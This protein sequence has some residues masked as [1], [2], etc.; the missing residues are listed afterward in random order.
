MPKNTYPYSFLNLILYF[1]KLGTVGF[2]GS[3]ALA[4]YMRHDLV[5]KKRWIT[6]EDYLHGLALSQ[7]APGPLSAQLAI[8]IGFIKHKIIGATLCGLAFVLPSFVIVVLLSMVYVTFGNL[9]WIQKALYGVN[10]A[11]IGIILF[12]CYRLTRTT[13]HTLLQWVIMICMFGIVI[14]TKQENI[15]L[16]IL[17]GLITLILSSPP[18]FLSSNKLFGI[19]IPLL[20]GGLLTLASMNKL[21][22]LFF[23]FLQAGALAFGGGFAII[24]F[25]L[26]GVV[27]QY[28]WLTNKEFVDA[29]AIAMVTPGPVVITAAFIGY[30]IGG[31]LGAG[32]ATIAIFLP[33]YLIVI[34]LTPL[35]IKYSKHPQMAA[36]IHGVTAAAMGAIAGSIVILGEQSITD[37]FT[38]ILALCS[39][40]AISKGKVPGVIIILLAGGASVLFHSLHF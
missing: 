22:T 35:F 1:L 14:I 4:E 23:F 37:V 20:F 15:L 24:P 12:S 2:G 5:E 39:L 34:L 28:H 18:K 27:H 40:L 29:V 6:N 33:I 11:I 13:V 3:I 17:A 16:F 8:Y 10:A 21:T 38:A 26:N 31:F 19:S 32:I 36:F 30:L 9:S 7:L 25:L